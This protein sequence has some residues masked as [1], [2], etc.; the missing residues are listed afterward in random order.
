MNNFYIYIIY[1][2]ITI[3][4]MNIMVKFFFIRN[5]LFKYLYF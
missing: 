3:K 2:K 1:F 5:H 4:L